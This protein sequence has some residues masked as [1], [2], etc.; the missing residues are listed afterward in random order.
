MRKLRRH[1][2]PLFSF[3]GMISLPT[4]SHH[5]ILPQQQ[6]AFGRGTETYSASSS[7]N[8]V[9]GS[10]IVVVEHDNDV[11][12]LKQNAEAN[13]T[14][15]QSKRKSHQQQTGS[16]REFAGDVEGTTV[17]EGSVAGAKKNA[18]AVIDQAIKRFEIP[19]DLEKDYR[20]ATV[21]KRTPDRILAWELGVRIEKNMM[22]T[23]ASSIAWQAKWN[24]RASGLSEVLYSWVIDVL[25][26]FGLLPSD[27]AGST[28]DG[29]GDIRRLLSKLLTAAFWE[30]CV[31]HLSNCALQ[32]SYGANLDPSKI[33]NIECRETLQTMRSVIEH[34]NKSPQGK[35]PVISHA[36]HRFLSLTKVN[37]RFL[38]LWDPIDKYYNERSKLS[39][40][41]LS[42]KEEL[43]QLY[44]LI[45]PVGALMQETQGCSKPSGAL[46]LVGL[47][48]P[49]LNTMSAA[50]LL[51][52]IRPS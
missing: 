34:L 35:Q 18:S 14:S 21:S 19:Q 2:R 17:D 47:A 26:E 5:L 49:Q 1:D 16:K 40:P 30:W 39:N 10:T 31:P 38:E 41:M 12:P 37:E 25:A 27:I 28:S 3:W 20:M 13:T 32:E 48:D 46:A 36:P 45:V 11:D 9:E 52:V 51:Q 29:G 6:R 42:L 23:L 7:G 50:A 4:F 33:G 8:I 44:S 43:R 24:T 15:Y 22:R